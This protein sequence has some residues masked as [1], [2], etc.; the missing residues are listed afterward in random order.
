[1]YIDEVTYL[2]KAYD[3]ERTDVVRTAEHVEMYEVVRFGPDKIAS[4]SEP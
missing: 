4:L 3:A 1:M 2:I